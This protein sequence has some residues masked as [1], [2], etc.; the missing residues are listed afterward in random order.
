MK[1]SKLLDLPFVFTALTNAVRL[2]NLIQMSMTMY[3][4]PRNLDIQQMNPL[5]NALRKSHL[6]CHTWT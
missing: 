5:G 3:V 1:I 2:T 6:F 4:V